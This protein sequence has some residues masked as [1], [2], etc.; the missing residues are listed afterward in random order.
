[1]LDSKI[2]IA[3]IGASR[4]AIIDNCKKCFLS[5]KSRGEKNRFDRAGWRH[6]DGMCPIQIKK[7]AAFL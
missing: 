3:I 2:F 1:M 5:Y 6:V 7:E 4:L